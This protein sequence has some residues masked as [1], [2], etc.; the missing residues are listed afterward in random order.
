MACTAEL[1]EQL[2]KIR[3]VAYRPPNPRFYFK[4]KL[5]PRSH[6]APQIT[7]ADDRQSRLGVGYVLDGSVRKAGARC[8]GGRRD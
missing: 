6:G 2:S 1:I 5:W 7:L 3:A 8:A 4:G